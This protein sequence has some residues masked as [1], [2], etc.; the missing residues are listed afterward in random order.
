MAYLAKSRTR[1]VSCHRLRQ[2]NEVSIMRP[3]YEAPSRKMAA[4]KL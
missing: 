2:E 1:F 3:T 4:I